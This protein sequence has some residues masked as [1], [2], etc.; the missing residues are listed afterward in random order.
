MANNNATSTSNTAIPFG[1]GDAKL[2]KI[3]LKKTPP[4]Q[5]PGVNR[6]IR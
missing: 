1:K 4:W 3:D 6:L 5:K 2:H